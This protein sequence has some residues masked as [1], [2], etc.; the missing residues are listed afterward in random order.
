[1]KQFIIEIVF[2]LGL[3]AGGSITIVAI[4]SWMDGIKSDTKVDKKDE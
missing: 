3:L 2:I 1:M 4:K